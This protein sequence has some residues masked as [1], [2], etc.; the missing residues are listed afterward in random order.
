VKYD[1]YWRVRKRLPERFG[2]P[3][4]VL[5]RGKLNS[6]L[7]EFLDGVKVITSRYYVRKLQNFNPQS[8]RDR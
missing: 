2:Q 5:A 7:V 1:R 4:R 8:L 3:C 6:C